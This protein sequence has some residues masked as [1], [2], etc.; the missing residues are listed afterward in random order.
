M[1]DFRD[2]LLI[3][4]KKESKWIMEFVTKQPL[5]QKNPKNAIVYSKSIF[6]VGESIIYIYIYYNLNYTCI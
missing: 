6:R 3:S 1:H 5:P 2:F 4:I